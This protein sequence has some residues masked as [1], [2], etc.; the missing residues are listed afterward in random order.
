M[1]RKLLYVALLMLGMSCMSVHP[2]VAQNASSSYMEHL[3]RGVVAL[4]AQGKGIFVSWRMLGTDSKNVCFDVVRDGK[5]I[6]SHIKATNYTDQDGTAAHT[7]QIV[8]Y[9]EMPKADGIAPR[10]VSQ[11]VKPWADLYQSLP[12]S[13]PKGGTTPDGRS[14]TYTPNDCSVGDVDGDGEYEIILKWDPS[15]SHDNSHNGYTGDVIFD[16]YKLSG[17]KLWRINL[18]K[19][20]RA[21]AHYTQFLVYDFDGD[22]K[23]EMI[24]KTSVGS[25]DG[26]GKFVNEAA[27]D[28]DIRSLDNKADYRNGAGRVQTGP[29]LLTVFNGKTGQ[30]IHTIWYNPNRAFGVGRQVAEGESL[31][32]G[33]PAYS[34]VWG[35]KGNYGNRGERYL[36]GVAFLDG[37][38]HLPSAVMCRGYY[39]RSYLWAVDFDGKQLKTKWLHASTTSGT[40]YA[41]GAHSLAVGDVDGD[42]CDEITY[43]S[44]AINNDGTLLYSTGLG[45]GDA[46]HLGDLDPDRPGLEYFMVHEEY[47]YGSDLR[48]AKTGEILYRTLDRDDTG[49]GLAADIDANHRGYEMW[50]SDN[51]E[52]RDCKGNVIVEAKDAWKKRSGEKKKKQA[53]Q[54][55]DWNSNEKTTFRAVSPMPAMNFRIYWDGDLQDELLANGRA[56]H[57]PPYIQKWNGKEAVALPLSN[58]KQL[59]EMGHSVSCNWTKATPNLQADL[60]GDWREEVVYWDESDAAHLN[61]FT[62]NIPT[63]YRVPTLMHDHIYRMGIAWQNVGYNQPPHLG[64]YLPDKAEKVSGE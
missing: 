19:N 52:V 63:D 14:Y 5:V 50:S 59:F 17:K 3:D 12:I 1:R 37:K 61:I 49:R 48:D 53:P 51:P 58:G 57:F 21:G 7:Y 64:Y 31:K 42:G 47:P 55:G 16:C 36:A 11:K 24:C 25:K 43:G 27:T 9:Q 38:D 20:I 45:H 28:E 62:T 46:Q 22:G 40:A 35:D 60:F 23:A 41:Q 26:K 6:A 8:T 2:I 56:P 30:A 29:E 15:N 10:E 54:Q 39:T 32:D 34:S 44:A 4:P 13:R 18:G 33:F